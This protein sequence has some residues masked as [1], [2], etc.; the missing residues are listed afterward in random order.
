MY[1]TW[2][3][4]LDDSTVCDGSQVG[5]ECEQIP[6]NSNSDSTTDS[7]HSEEDEEE[8][9]EQEGFTWNTREPDGEAGG[10]YL[11]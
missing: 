1:C 11:K 3:Y 9:E 7:E 6:L 5:L 4:R 10:V 8:Q 2:F